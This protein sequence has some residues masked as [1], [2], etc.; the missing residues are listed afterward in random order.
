MRMVQVFE[1]IDATWGKVEIWDERA[2]SARVAGD[3]VTSVAAERHCN[4]ACKEARRL[5]EA[6]SFMP[7]MTPA[8]A[9]AA[10]SRVQF[11]LG[12][13]LAA[14]EPDPI[15]AQMAKLTAAVKVWLEQ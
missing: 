4:E 3:G 9:V 1:Q 2:I 6:V 5:E 11:E 14:E 15:L 8:D 7:V 10:L 12:E 13:R